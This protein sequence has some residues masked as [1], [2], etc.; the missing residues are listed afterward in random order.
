MIVFVL[1]YFAMELI[2]L[3]LRLFY[4][5]LSKNNLVPALKNDFA[6]LYAYDREII[7]SNPIKT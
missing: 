2:Y 1:G 5:V 6:E 3:V 4:H 7:L